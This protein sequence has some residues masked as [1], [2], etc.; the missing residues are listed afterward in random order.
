[1][2]KRKKNTKPATQETPAVKPDA[3]GVV[4]SLDLGPMDREAT[5]QP[6]DDDEYRFELSVSSETPVERW[7]GWEILDH[8]VTAV[9]LSRF[10][11]GAAV[12]DEHYGDQI[13]VVESAE[14]RADRRVHAVIR[15]GKSARAEEIRQDIVDNIRRNVSVRYQANEMRLE[16][17][18]KDISTYRITDWSIVH[19]AIVPDPA[20]KA[21]GFGRSKD[22]ATRS[23]SIEGVPEL[24]KEQPQP[25]KNEDK[26]M[27][28]EERKAL[29]D[30]LAQAHVTSTAAAEN[31]NREIGEILAIAG[32][33]DMGAQAATHIS[34]GKTLDEFRGLVIE[35][36]EAKPTT[37]EDRET[38]IG[39]NDKEIKEYRFVRALHCLASHKPLDG[40]EREAS[41]AVAKKLHRDPK[42]FFVPFD[43]Q[44]SREFGMVGERAL[45]V[46]T[47]SQGG[48]TVGEE[49][50]SGSMIE[51]LRNKMV[52]SSLGARNLSGLV[53]DIAIP[54][55]TSGATTYWL[56]ETEEIT[57]S[58]QAFAQLGLT[59]HRLAALTKYSKQLL[60]QS[61][62]D[63]EAF[64]RDDITTAIAI[65]KDLAAING[66]GAAG[67]PLGIV[68]TT[69]VNATVT[70]GGAPTWADVVEFETGVAVDNADVRNM[71]YLTTPSVRGKWK[72]VEKASSTGQFLWADNDSPVNGYR[73]EVTNQVPGNKV[74]FGDFSQLILA[75]W[76]GMDVVV[77]PFTLAAFG[78]IRIIITIMTDVGVRQPLAFNVSVDA[79]NQ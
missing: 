70:F 67:Q 64:V 38:K 48:Y 5:I 56:S 31:R 4:R 57:E 73:A 43:I 50:L 63:I 52:I 60:S 6:T 36:L 24:A 8:S 66:S 44:A 20:D 45:N 13:G 30:K 71:A 54:K 68:N 35:K 17:E 22:D 62:L 69:G 51:L 33:H 75:D 72:T 25:K 12:R 40:L 21:V 15:L 11:D 3:D 34:E 46:T 74:I 16:K 37:L 53:G 77:D 76:S 49:L 9:D 61:S 29:E 14:V 78:Q 27:T 1:M 39:M 47:P 23:I 26:D 7:F 42:G 32:K 41:D 10:N 28:D 58:E 79:G 18:E 2:S 19:L 65:A 55:V 59:P